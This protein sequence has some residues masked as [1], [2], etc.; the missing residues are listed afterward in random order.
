[1]YVLDSKSS[2]VQPEANDL[3]AGNH[4]ARQPRNSFRL[5]RSLAALILLLICANSVSGQVWLW[6]INGN[7]SFSNTVY[8]LGTQPSSSGAVA[9]INIHAGNGARIM[10]ERTGEILMGPGQSYSN[11]GLTIRKD[12]GSAL[13][14][15]QTAA[16][17][18]NYGLKIHAAS[19]LT[20][21]LAVRGPNMSENF[22]VYADG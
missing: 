2:G 4:F 11:T 14:L 8:Q 5:V 16:A 13:I 7:P 15:D 18:Y 20:K 12:G 22:L 10:M 17:N 19:A 3:H 21:A 9:N 1:M 6:N